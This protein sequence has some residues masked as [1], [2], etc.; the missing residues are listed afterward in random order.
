MFILD[1]Y[2]NSSNRPACRSI[3]QPP[4]NGAGLME[5]TTLIFNHFFQQNFRIKHKFLYLDIGF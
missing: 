4:K 1:I 3:F 2:R 5:G